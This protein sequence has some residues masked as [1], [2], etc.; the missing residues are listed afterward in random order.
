MGFLDSLLNI[1]VQ[2]FSNHGERH[3]DSQPS[4]YSGCHTLE[5]SATSFRVGYLGRVIKAPMDLFRIVWEGWTDLRYSV[6]DR[7]DVIERLVSKAIE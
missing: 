2:A 5:G 3:P 4:S 7:D 6:T 1:L